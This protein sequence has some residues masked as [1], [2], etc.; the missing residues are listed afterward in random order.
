MPLA[1][2]NEYSSYDN[3]VLLILLAKSE[4]PAFR[5]IYKRFWQRLFVIA[6][7]RLKEIQTAEDIVHDVFASLWVNRK[8]SEIDC[9][10]NYLATAAKYMVLAKI[11]K[12][13]RERLYNNSQHYTPVFEMHVEASLH[14]KRILE[15]VKNEIEELLNFT[16]Y[17]YF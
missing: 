12:K 11:K 14:Y 4:E 17:Y 5:E 13:E 8:R 15:L 10:E 2:M 3:K 6:Y 9:L 16:E 7:N 1:I